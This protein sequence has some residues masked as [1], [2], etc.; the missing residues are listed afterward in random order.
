MNTNSPSHCVCPRRSFK[1]HCW[2]AVTGLSLWFAGN[3]LA[4]EVVYDNT[5]TAATSATSQPNSDVPIFGDSLSL[6]HGGLLSQLEPSLYNSSAGGN[7]GSILTGDMTVKF[8]D[9]TS[10]YTGGTL[11]LPL[12]GTTALSWDFTSIGGLPVGYYVVQQFDLASLNLSLPA[13]I[14]ITQQFTETTGTSTRHGVVLFGN[15]TVGSS[16]DTV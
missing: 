8:Y 16:P 14:L 6:T 12:L 5:G 10:P 7:S 15:P 13:E 1:V 9:N 3:A 4:V 2:L 11:S